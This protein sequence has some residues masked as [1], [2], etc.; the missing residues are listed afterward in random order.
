MLKHGDRAT[1]HDDA[2][3]Q[4]DDI[5]VQRS[6]VAVQRD[7]VLIQCDYVSNHV[8]TQ[9]LS[10]GTFVCKH[11]CIILSLLIQQQVYAVPNHVNPLL[12]SINY[13]RVYKTSRVL[14]A[15]R[16]EEHW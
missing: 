10:V 8:Q 6:D 3:I 14:K 16:A 11:E 4:R 9:L 1:Q 2:M 7:D 13:R 15:Y 12:S 5:A